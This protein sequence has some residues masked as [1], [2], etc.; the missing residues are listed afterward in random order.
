MNSGREASVRRVRAVLRAGARIADAECALGAEARRR[1]VDLAVLSGRGVELALGE[2]LETTATDA[3]LDALVTSVEDAP[4]V[5]VLLSAN[6]CT[7]ALRALAL[8]L[9]AAPDVYIRPSRRD[10]VLAELLIQVLRDDRAFCAEGATAQLVDSLNARAG[11]AVHL[12]GSDETLE[13]VRDSLPRGVSVS[14]HG[15]GYGVAV[16]GAEAD[17]GDSAAALA[18]DVIVF[19]QAGCLSPRVVLVEG[20]VDRVETVASELHRAMTQLGAAIPR[21][22]LGGETEADIARYVHTI[23]TVGVAMVGSEH[24]I[25]VDFT[26]RALLLPPAARVVHVV[27]TQPSEA[28]KL[29]S[30]QAR[31]ITVVG[32]S[33]E[34]S[35]VRAVCAVAPHA[36]RSP[37]GEM[38]RPPLDGPVDRRPR[39]DD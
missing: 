11:D 7:A 29:L 17:V 28:S 18:R 13:A 16:L 35:L 12:Y 25:G 24:V 5:H 1:L 19:D 31:F 21:G 26:P 4:R 22:M 27:R 36:R 38:Q 37:L 30:D 23:Q 14:A 8:A 20:D 3:E 34:A 39:A 32:A 9:A 15:T 10:P 6:V 33:D 2:H